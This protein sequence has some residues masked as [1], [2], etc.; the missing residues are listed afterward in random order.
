LVLVALLALVLVELVEQGA[1]L[2]LALIH[3]PVA[4][5]V[6]VVHLLLELMEQTAVL[7]VV[8]LPEIAILGQVELETHQAQAHHKETMVVAF[9]HHKMEI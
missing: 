3:L 8:H 4:V 9:H 1:I 5:E 2:Y 7:A 6:E